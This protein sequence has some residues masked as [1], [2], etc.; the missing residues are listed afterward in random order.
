MTDSVSMIEIL[1][2]LLS[3]DFAHLGQ[4]IA[5]V[6]AAG[7]KIVDIVVPQAEQAQPYIMGT[8]MVADAADRHRIALAE[9]PDSFGEEVLRRSVRVSRHATR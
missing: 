5:Q 4:H 6:E 2:S 3:A 8:L 1:P 7:A 9:Q